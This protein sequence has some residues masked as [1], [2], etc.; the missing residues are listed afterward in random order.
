ME[1]EFD[2]ATFLAKLPSGH[3]KRAAVGLSGGVDSAVCTAILKEQGFDVLAVHM[4]NW[5]ETQSTQQE[6]TYCTAQK[7]QED[8]VKVAEALGV[9][10]YIMILS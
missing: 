2:A 6:G 3:G 4:V 5:Q 9:P 8:A 7:D 1:F 10:Y